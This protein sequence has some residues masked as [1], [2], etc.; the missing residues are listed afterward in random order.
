MN[1]CLISII[2]PAFNCEGTIERCLASVTGQAYPSNFEI[3]IIV[4]DDG[5]TD[6]TAKICERI[7]AEDGRITVVRK[8]NG[9][10]SSARNLGLAHAEGSYIAFL[11]ADDEYEPGFLAFLV[12]E[13]TSSGADLVEC[14]FYQE[15]RSKVEP[16]NET[17]RTVVMTRDEAICCFALENCVSPNIWSKV[18]RTELVGDLRFDENMSIAEDRDFIFKYLQRCNRVVHL[19]TCLYLYRY[20]A[21]SLMHRGYNSEL[22]D[23]IRFAESF[24]AWGCEAYPENED[25]FLAQELR[26]K[27]RVIRLY[28]ADGND[29]GRMPQDL[30]DVMRRVRSMPYEVLLRLPPRHALL[31]SVV[32]YAPSLLPFL[33]KIT[34]RKGK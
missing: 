19:G 29:M 21:A 15:T 33:S 16:R 31:C 9:G 23:S 8:Q 34:G 18:F 11:D 2:V 22:F 27:C 20:T 26:N 13:M 7:A 6:D 24:A 1:N 17:G 14:A 5:S 4:V 28:I 3:Q 10:V 30:A 25:I 32:K 12:G